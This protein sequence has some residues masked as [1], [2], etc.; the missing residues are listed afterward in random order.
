MLY[1]QMIHS[2]LYSASRIT[3]KTVAVAALF[4]DHN[5]VSMG[6]IVWAEDTIATVET[7]MA[8]QEDMPKF[9]LATEAEARAEMQ[10]AKQ[11]DNIRKGL[12]L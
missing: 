4:S 6:M 9:Q 3:L 8:K 1:A 5:V 11:L 7:F 12:G 10:R 2:L